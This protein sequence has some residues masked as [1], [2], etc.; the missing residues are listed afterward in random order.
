[1]S[2]RRGLYKI[3]GGAELS[4]I[5]IPRVVIGEISIPELE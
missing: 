2:R 3:S 4:R 1:L 5:E